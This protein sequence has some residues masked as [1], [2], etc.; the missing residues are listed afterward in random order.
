MSDHSPTPPAFSTLHHT[1][2]HWAVRRLDRLFAVEP[3][4]QVT[5]A[6]ALE[7]TLRLA[8]AFRAANLGPGDRIAVLSSNR[9]EV[10]LLYYAASAAGATVVPRRARY[11]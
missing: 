10:V 5:Y 1:L 2:D 7:A 3:G 8:S 6:D 11:R 9:V 4:R